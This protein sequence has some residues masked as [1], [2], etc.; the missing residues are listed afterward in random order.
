MFPETTS[1]ETISPETASLETAPATQTATLEM[2][3]AEPPRDVPRSPASSSA[4]PRPASRKSCGGV[5]VI[6]EILADRFRV[7][8]FLGQGGMGQV[9]EAFDL[10]LGVSV[11]VKAIRPEQ[12]RNPAAARRFKQEVHLA[13]QVT[14]GNVCRIFDLFLHHQQSAWGR[15]GGP[16]LFLTMELLEGESLA[17]FL[18]R[19]GPLAP[20]EALPLVRDMAA[21]LDAAHAAGIVHQDFKSSNIMLVSSGGRRRAVVTDF[22]LAHTPQPSD[23][24]SGRGGGT[25]AYMAPEQWR[26]DPVTAAVDVYSFGVVLCEMLTGAR[27][28]LPEAPP[29]SDSKAPPKVAAPAKPEA[30]L[31]L[32]ALERCLEENPERRFQQAGEVVEAIAGPRRRRRRLLAAAALVAGLGSAGLLAMGFPERQVEPAILAHPGALQRGNVPVTSQDPER[33]SELYEQALL[34]LDRFD[35]LGARDLLEEAVAVDRDAIFPRAVL[36]GLLNNLGELPEARDAAWEAWELADDLPELQ[37]LEIEARYR[38]TM[39]ESETAVALFGELTERLPERLDLGLKRVWAQFRAGMRAE[40]TETLGALRARVSDFEAK[41]PPAAGRI[42][43]MAVRGALEYSDFPTAFDAAWR[44][45]DIARREGAPEL[46]VQALLLVGETEWRQGRLDAAEDAVLAA[47]ALAIQLGLDD[48]VIRLL[49][50]RGNIALSRQ[51]VDNAAHFY[52]KLIELGR[53]HRFERMML[54]GMHNLGVLYSEVGRLQDARRVFDHFLNHARR[55][56]MERNRLMSLLNLA[57]VATQQG[58]VEAARRFNEQGRAAVAF[59]RPLEAALLDSNRARL[60]RYSGDLDQSEALLVDCRDRLEALGARLNVVWVESSLGDVSFQR[61]DVDEAR[62]RYESALQ[63]AEKTGYHGAS[64]L[65]SLARLALESGEPAEALRLAMDVLQRLDSQESVTERVLTR[66][67]LSRAHLAL[68]D[69]TEAERFYGKAR[70]LAGDE[71]EIVELGLHLDLTAVRVEAARDLGRAKAQARQASADAL[72]AGSFE[73]QLE[74]RRILGELELA[75]G[76]EGPGQGAERL[77]AVVTDARRHG[78][79]LSVQNAVKS[80]ES[81]EGLQG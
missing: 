35:V 63:R 3:L 52:E 61:G 59:G 14:H 75:A 73:L 37:R 74:A 7:D 65:R 79:G 58:D 38:L 10:E 50:L 13:R 32:P 42:E 5:F 29:G 24:R 23:E 25:P 77:H 1:S 6:G 45:V 40:A 62:R 33:A 4:S 9:Y 12:N 2:G 49:R 56:G 28:L 27:P 31:W 53:R 22:G 72:E 43:I 48:A 20:S 51:D 76:D 54:T 66:L 18:K 15:Q 70:E 44:A 80:L 16:I 71:P 11:A 69:F 19:R 81:V 68:G 21:A 17:A 55:R 41:G 8:R 57:V 60:F 26:G 39:R 36:A 30:S 78:F 64:M 34:K 47:Q 67:I 46:E